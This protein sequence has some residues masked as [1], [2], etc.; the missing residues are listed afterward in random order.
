MTGKQ[1]E[2]PHDED[3]PGVPL[4]RPGHAREVADAI[5]WLASAESSY[6]TGTSFIIDGG[7]TLMA[8]EANRRL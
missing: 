8:A 2:N 5:P 6:V 1:D 3:R 7:L 4:G